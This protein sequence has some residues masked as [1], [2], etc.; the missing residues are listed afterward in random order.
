VIH[1]YTLSRSK[2]VNYRTIR[3]KNWSLLG[4]LLGRRARRR[5]RQAGD[6]AVVGLVLAERLLHVLLQLAEAHPLHLL[7]VGG[8]P[9]EVELVKP[10]V[11]QVVLQ[12]LVQHLRAVREVPPAQLHCKRPDGT[13][14]H[15]FLTKCISCV[16]LFYTGLPEFGVC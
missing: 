1:P 13:S 7:L 5:R 14:E 15:L 16:M 3:G 8:A 10:P 6:H 2:T 11:R 4:D 12:E 9:L